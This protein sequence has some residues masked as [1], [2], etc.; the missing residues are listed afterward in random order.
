MP[1]KQKTLNINLLLPVIREGF[2][3]F[4]FRFL[5]DQNM[6]ASMPLLCALLR[7]FLNHSDSN[8]AHYLKYISYLNETV[9]LYETR[10]RQ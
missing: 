9:R 3:D 1:S 6:F 5:N 10:A 8:V 2:R 4:A 7:C